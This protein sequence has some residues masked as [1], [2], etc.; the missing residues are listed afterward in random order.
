MRFPLALLLFV[1]MPLAYAASDDVRLSPTLCVTYRMYLNGEAV[2]LPQGYDRLMTEKLSTMG[3]RPAPCG[4]A[5]I[6]LSVAMRITGQTRENTTVLIFVDG[7]NGARSGHYQTQFSGREYEAQ[8]TQMI[9]SMALGLGSVMVEI[10]PEYTQK[11]LQK[12]LEY[13]RQVK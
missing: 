12:L 8:P 5:Q 2:P 10:D 4:T 13:S 9:Q 11:A 6:R 7:K 3:Y 1:S